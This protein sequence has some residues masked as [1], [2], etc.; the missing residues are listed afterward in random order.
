M[1]PNN[2][3]R[4]PGLGLSL[5]NRRTLL[6]IGADDRGAFGVEVEDKAAQLISWPVFKGGVW[7]AHL[8]PSLP[9]FVASSLEPWP[10]SSPAIWSPFIGRHHMCGAHHGWGSV[11]YSLPSINVNPREW[12]KVNIYRGVKS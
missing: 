4:S 2:P 7:P 12:I 9:P 6:L 1:K 11:T 3:R 5:H 8:L 10:S